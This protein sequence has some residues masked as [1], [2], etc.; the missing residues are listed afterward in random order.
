MET[1]REAGE[2]VRNL[3]RERDSLQAELRGLREAYKHARGFLGRSE[4][5]QVEHTY[6]AALA[7]PRSGPWAQKC[8]DGGC[9]KLL[10]GG[11]RCPPNQCAIAPHTGEEG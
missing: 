1:A 11:E 3:Q 8:L 2:Y 9:V 10:H 6:R 7:A 5:E 4:L